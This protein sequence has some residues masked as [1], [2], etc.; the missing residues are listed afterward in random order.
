MSALPEPLREQE[1]NTYVM[2]A[3]SAAEMAR[4]MRQDQ[5]LTAEM[6]GVF[7]EQI[8]LSEIQRVVDL[9]CGPGGWALEVAYTYSDIEV[10]GVDI[11]E[12][13]IAYAKAQAAVQHRANAQFRTMN[14]LHHLDFPDASF[15]LVNARLISGFILREQW[16]HFLQECLRILRPGGILRVTEL[17]IG[18]T[19]KPHLEQSLHTI[20]AAMARVGINFS[21]GGRDFGIIHMLPYLFRQAHVSAVR[22]QAHFIE[23]SADTDAH[24]SFYHDVDLGLQ[25]VESLVT[26]TQLMTTEDWRQLHQ[27]SMA[28]MFEVDFCAAW[29]LLTVW[30]NKPF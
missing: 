28:N 24:E 13:M 8:D 10:V 17:E 23:F 7:P 14:I 30:G 4:L 2:D 16:A 21:P 22:K 6:G 27:R 9:A 19:N 25:L 3:E 18:P 15:D 12:R 20:M 26:R 11:S 5:L 1:Q 29:I